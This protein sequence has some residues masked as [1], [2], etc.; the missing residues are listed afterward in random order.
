MFCAAWFQ[1]HHK[2]YTMAIVNTIFEIPFTPAKAWSN[3]LRAQLDLNSNISEID[4][5][6]AYIS[7]HRLASGMNLHGSESCEDSLF[8]CQNFALK[9]QSAM[10]CSLRMKMRETSTTCTVYL[11]LSL[12][13]ANDWQVRNWHR[14]LTWTH[15]RWRPILAVAP[16]H[17]IGNFETFCNACWKLKCSLVARGARVTG[18]PGAPC[19][20]R[21]VPVPAWTVHF[22]RYELPWE[23]RTLPACHQSEPGEPAS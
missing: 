2:M 8:N 21:G 4:H 5:K 19:D 1:R 23:R 17:Y 15:G 14:L 13:K 9:I 18:S 16:T 10:Q 6:L 7:L 12:S 22:S 11:W 3:S 20:E